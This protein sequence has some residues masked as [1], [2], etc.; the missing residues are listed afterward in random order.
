MLFFYFTSIFLELKIMS[1]NK[2]RV[3]QWQSKVGHTNWQP[4][5]KGQME[6]E[7]PLKWVN[8][9]ERWA[10]SAPGDSQFHT[11]TFSPLS[12]HG[13][14]CSLKVRKAACATQRNLFIP[15]NKHSVHCNPA[16]DFNNTAPNFASILSVVSGLSFE[17]GED[18]RWLVPPSSLFTTNC[19]KH[20]I[21]GIAKHWSQIL[22][23]VLWVMLPAVWI[24]FCGWAVCCA[25][26]ALSNYVKTEGH[27]KPLKIY[28][29]II[30]EFLKIDSVTSAMYS[31]KYWPHSFFYFCHHTKMF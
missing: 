23:V 30:M 24:V 31:A 12:E 14:G 4:K 3:L 16:D 1:D 11:S 8:W 29:Y 2:K 13:L 10:C 21:T 9:S 20:K 27:E 25:V 19:P 28:Y 26:G 15:K 6:L 17:V 18:C 5:S 7:I 22:F